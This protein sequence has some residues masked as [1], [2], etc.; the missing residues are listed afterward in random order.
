LALCWFRRFQDKHRDGQEEVI[1]IAS[2]LV[3]VLCRHYR[4]AGYEW[5]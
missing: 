2:M 5:T 4:G 3:R 1:E